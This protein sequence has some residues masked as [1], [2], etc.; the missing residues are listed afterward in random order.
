M[1]KEISNSPEIQLVD[2][3]VV[4]VIQEGG[5]ISEDLLKVEKPPKTTIFFPIN[6]SEQHETAGSGTHWTL[7]VAENYGPKIVGF[8]HYNSAGSAIPDNAMKVAK[9]FRAKFLMRDSL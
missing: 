7:L 3:S 9:N 8:G 1:R 5:E 4:R 2:P 6:N